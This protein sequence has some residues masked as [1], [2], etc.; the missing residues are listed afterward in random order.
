MPAT[1]RD[2]QLRGQVLEPERPQLLQI[3]LHKTMMSGPDRATQTSSLW[4]SQRLGL[5]MVYAVPAK[6]LCA[7]DQI[8]VQ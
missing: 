4:N 2:R 1:H 8:A 6:P 5:S 7:T 3:M